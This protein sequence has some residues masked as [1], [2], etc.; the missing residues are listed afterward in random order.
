MT[1]EKQQPPDMAFLAKR[2]RMEHS[3]TIAKNR[4]NIALEIIGLAATSITD[5]VSW[6]ENGNIKVKSSKSLKPHAARSIK[7]IRTFTDKDGNKKFELE[8]HD[9]IAMLRLLAKASGLLEQQENQ[10]KPSVIGI[11]IKA[12]VTIDQEDV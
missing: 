8:M 2:H 12:P 4:E 1:D 5:V 3:T 10:D 7:K 6:D 11:N 9:K